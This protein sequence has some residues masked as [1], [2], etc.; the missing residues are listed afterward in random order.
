MDC[1]KTMETD[2]SQSRDEGIAGNIAGRDVEFICQFNRLNFHVFRDAESYGCC[3]LLALFHNAIVLSKSFFMQTQNMEEKKSVTLGIRVQPALRKRLED[4]E[5]VTGVSVATMVCASLKSLCDYVE[6]HK[7]I[8]MPL[9]T[10]PQDEWDS[11]KKV[12]PAPIATTKKASVPDR[13]AGLGK[14]GGR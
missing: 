1:R 12:I 8:T 13:R 11:L 2:Y 7:K 10:R 5:S 4:A 6:E 14:T 9:V 3:H